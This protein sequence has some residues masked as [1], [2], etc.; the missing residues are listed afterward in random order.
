MT[1]SSG[2]NVSQFPEGDAMKVLPNMLDSQLVFDE[3]GHCYYLNGTPVPSVTGVLGGAGVI[4]YGFLGA[5]RELYL[6]RGQAV[7]LA[8]R[9]DDDGDLAASSLPPEIVEYLEAWRAFKRAYCFR[10]M[11]IEHRVSNPQYGYA[12]TL[13]RAGSIRDGTEILVDIK[14]G[15]AP[16]WTAVQLAAYAACLPHP[17]TRRRRCV[18]LHRDGTYRVIPY[19][20]SDYQRDFDTFARALETFRAKEE[21]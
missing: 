21:K 18:E 11:L 20:T 7:H 19:E 4:D 9:Y 6:A 8:A 16:A 17:R 13:D 10:P 3:I 1:P 14:T 12:G 15:V 2:R 5:R